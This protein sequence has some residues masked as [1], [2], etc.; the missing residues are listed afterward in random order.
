[1]RR[2]SDDDENPF[3]GVF[4]GI[5][6]MLSGMTDDETVPIDIHEYDDEIRVVADIPDANRDEI[7]I[8]CDGRSLV[9]QAEREPRPYVRRV[10]LPGYVDEQSEKASFNNGILEITLERDTDPANIGF[11]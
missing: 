8:Q 7:D 6:G 9:I 3:G 1:M 10:D 2:N 11:Q 4:G 5:D